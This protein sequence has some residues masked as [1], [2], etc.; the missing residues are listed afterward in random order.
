MKAL[1]TWLG[2]S[3]LLAVP[4]SFI[5]NA[6][7]NYY[8]SKGKL[9]YYFSDHLDPEKI[10]AMSLIKKI[11]SETEML[12]LDQEAYLIYEM[13][14]KTEKIKGDLAEVGVYKGAS[15]KLI[16]EASKKDLHLFDTFEGLPGL[17]RKDDPKKFQKGDFSASIESVKS[18][19]KGY[20]NIRFYKGLFPSTAEP[21]RNKKFS[22]AHLDVD[23][24]D[25]TLNCLKW[26]YP[27]LSK[28]GVII[29]HD[30]LSSKGVGK[31]FDEFFADKPE[32]IIQPFVTGQCLVVK[33]R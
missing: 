31:A 22:F 3:K 17:N 14:R 13:V 33:V 9:V 4:R 29:S 18:Y 1:L 12:L 19:L 24:Y 30:Y 27:R 2:T 7:A 8:K 5:G 32:I 20:P 11:K 25:S 28:G 10:R 15:A 26:F 23:V 16:R 6:L 21:V